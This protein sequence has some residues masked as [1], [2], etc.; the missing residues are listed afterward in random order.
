[1]SH[2]QQRT[3]V[4]SSEEMHD[5]LNQVYENYYNVPWQHGAGDTGPSKHSSRGAENQLQDN[6]SASQ[7]ITIGVCPY[8]I[9]ATRTVVNYHYLKK[10]TISTQLAPNGTARYSKQATIILPVGRV[11]ILQQEKRSMPAKVSTDESMNF[12]R[13]THARVQCMRKSTH[14]H[15]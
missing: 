5:R 13:D 8:M 15:A 2:H 7:A 14:M 12:Q 10:L 3:A 9:V 11:C 1:V 6:N 4:T